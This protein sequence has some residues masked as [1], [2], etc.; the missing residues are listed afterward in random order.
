MSLIDFLNTKIKNPEEYDL[1]EKYELVTGYDEDYDVETDLEK[2]HELW[3]NIPEIKEPSNFISKCIKDTYDLSFYEK[4]GQDKGEESNVTDRRV[5][6]KY[7][8]E[9]GEA[10]KKKFNEL[11]EKPSKEIEKELHVKPKKKERIVLLGTTPLLVPYVAYCC[12]LLQ[13]YESKNYQLKEIPYI[14]YSERDRWSSEKNIHF[15]DCIS[16][17]FVKGN[18]NY[19]KVVILLQKEIKNGWFNCMPTTSEEKSSSKRSKSSSKRSKSSY[20]EI[21]KPRITLAE[22]YRFE[23]MV[24]K[25]NPKL[26]LHIKI[27]STPKDHYVIT[28]NKKPVGFGSTVERFGSI[29]GYGGKKHT[30][31]MKRTNRKSK[32][33]NITRKR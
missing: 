2:Y 22:M 17:H 18:K 7:S 4:Q 19:K 14:I 11:F 5:Y 31:K 8:T 12:K 21:C 9:I 13:E 16:S 29:T 3:T 26:K 24:N 27:D 1:E 30:R 20:K 32:N 25:L 15:I 33:H 23:K 10:D 6:I 28:V